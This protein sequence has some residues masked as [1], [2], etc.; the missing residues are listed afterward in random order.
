MRFG[1]FFGLNIFWW[2]YF[3]WNDFGRSFLRV[4]R[5]VRTTGFSILFQTIVSVSLQTTEKGKIG[6]IN[7]FILSPLRRGG[8]LNTVPVVQYFNSATHKYV[9]TINWFAYCYGRRLSCWNASIAAWQP[10]RFPGGYCS[11]L[12]CQ[13]HWSIQNWK[14]VSKNTRHVKQTVDKYA[15]CNI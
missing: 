3:G 1:P 14:V 4:D 15:K 11:I 12:I 7:C 6:S 5:S 2:T 8:G 9:I 10:T 13:C